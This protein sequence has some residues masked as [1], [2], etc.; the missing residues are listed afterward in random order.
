MDIFKLTEKALGFRFHNGTKWQLKTGPK[1]PSTMWSPPV[2]ASPQFP[3]QLYTTPPQPTNNTTILNQITTLQK[4]TSRLTSG[5]LP[6]VEIILEGIFLHCVGDW[7]MSAKIISNSR[8]STLSGKIRLGSCSSLPL[9][10][11]L[12][13]FLWPHTFG[14]KEEALS[15]T[16]CQSSTRQNL[17]HTDIL[18]FVRNSVS[19]WAHRVFFPLIFIGVELLYNVVSVFA[20]QQSESAIHTH[21]SPLFWTS[22]PFRSPKITE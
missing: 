12:L 20:V 5:F 6:F 21:I 1:R 19:Y 7:K 3:T 22:F 16:Y 8:C 9:P 17:K 11:P 4:E 18:L 2:Q 13:F 10:F 15:C 14:E